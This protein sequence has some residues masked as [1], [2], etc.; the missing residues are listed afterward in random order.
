LRWEAPCLTES[1][2][3]LG[4]RPSRFLFRNTYSEELQMKKVLTAVLLAVLATG[5]VATSIG[6]GPAAS[7]GSK[8]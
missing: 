1:S 4:V 5:F 3:R 8:K 7:T 2:V 6:C